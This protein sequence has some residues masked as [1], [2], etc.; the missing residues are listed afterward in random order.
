MQKN[1]DQIQVR[2]PKGKK[3]QVQ[4]HAESKGESVNAFINRAIDHE[5]DRDTQEGEES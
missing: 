4:A 2:T 1:Y 3:E 5:M